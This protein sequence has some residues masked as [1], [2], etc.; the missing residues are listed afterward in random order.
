MLNCPYCA[1]N[2]VTI[3]KQAKLRMEVIRC[4]CLEL[5][6]VWLSHINLGFIF[7][8]TALHPK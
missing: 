4:Q 8:I 3:C 5:G 6:V 2:Y 7:V 1:Q